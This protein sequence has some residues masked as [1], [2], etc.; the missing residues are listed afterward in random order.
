MRIV[1]EGGRANT[2]QASVIV[3]RLK[4]LLKLHIN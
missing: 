4:T 3:L 1:V 2:S